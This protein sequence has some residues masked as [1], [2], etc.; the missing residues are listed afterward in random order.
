MSV[1][2]RITAATRMGA[3]A[4]TGIGLGGGI[5]VMVLLLW[6]LGASPGAVLSLIARS[7]SSPSLQTDALV[8]AI[9]ILLIALGSCLCFRAGF[10]NI[11]G[12]AYFYGGG[13]AATTIGLKLGGLPA[14]VLILLMAAA[15]ATA[16]AMLSGIAGVLKARRSINEVVVT[17]M[18]N[19]AIIQIVAYTVRSPLAD[20]ASRLAFSQNLPEQAMLGSA[21]L[22]GLPRVHIGVYV[23][24]LAV[25]AVAYIQSRTVFGH[26]LR[27]LGQNA[28]AAIGSGID[29]P[30]AIIVASLAMG[31][32]GGLAGMLHVAGTAGNLYVGLSP[33]PGFGYVAIMIA[34]L[35]GTNA[36]GAAFATLLYAALAGASDSLQVEFGIQRG[37]VNILFAVV[38][39]F[40]LMTDTVLRPHEG[41][42]R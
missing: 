9:P 2:A 34:L 21:H 32:L 31:G 39:L 33:A 7:L 12:E 36:A 22:L 35:A 15:A 1:A 25:V 27:V 42:V 38:V 41:G 3:T 18:A 23:A 10:W 14:P 8:Q 17:L 19:L 4:R 6:A 11:G 28:Y 24:A 20:P 30:R 5:V 37:F 13:I 40:V 16:G 26:V 29:A